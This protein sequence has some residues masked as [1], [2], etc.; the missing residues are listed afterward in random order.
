MRKLDEVAKVRSPL[1]TFDQPNIVPMDLRAF[2]I[3]LL[4]ELLL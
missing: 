2:G 4:G 3:S 1:P